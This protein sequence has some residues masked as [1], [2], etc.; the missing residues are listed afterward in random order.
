M[1]V[2]FVAY[3]MIDNENGDSLIGVYKRALRIGLEMGRRGHEI[4]MFCTGRQGYQDDLTQ[5]AQDRI[6]FIDFPFELQFSPSARLRRRFYRMAFRKLRLD[7]V[8]VGEAPLTGPLLE[9]AHCAVGLGIRVIVLDNAY[10]PGLSQDFVDCHGP[11][12]D[13]IVL[14]GPSSFHS[15]HTPS[16]YCSVPP[17]IEGS[18]EEAATR[19]EQLQLG[20]KRLVTVL[21]YEQKAEQLAFAL[22][23][24][25]KEDGCGMIVL[26]RNPEQCRERVQSKP[27]SLVESLRILPPPNENLLFGLLKLSNLVIGKCG[28][29]QVTESLAVRTPFLAIQYRG[30]FPVEY[31]PPEVARFV[32]ATNTV[33][34]DLRTIK[35]AIR[36]VH[37]SPQELNHIHN[38]EF[39]ARS[40]VVD[41]LERLPRAPRDTREQCLQLGYS[42]SLILKAIAAI[43]GRSAVI[44]HAIRCNRVRKLEWGSLDSLVCSYTIGGAQKSCLLWGRAYKSARK[45]KPDLRAAALPNSGRKILAVNSDRCILLE[46]DT[47]Q[48]LPPLPPC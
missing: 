8:V 5:Q 4:Y 44:V 1:R 26:T 35:A 3:C 16:Y 43:H 41:F 24:R 13:G 22:W 34:P 31:L 39:G 27:P 2:L 42:S 9:A 11:M 20:N 21:G 36:F 47:G 23:P 15:V 28:F 30:C 46:E 18:E 10:N 14:T 19:I 17:Y 32:H 33:V 7:M 29:M 25:L 40:R 6:R 37:T 48:P 45:A 12:L 38:G